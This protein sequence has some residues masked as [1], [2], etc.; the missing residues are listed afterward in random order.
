M[1][2]VA[3]ER[4]VGGTF[5]ARQALCWQL[6]ATPHPCAACHMSPKLKAAAGAGGFG[7]GGDVILG[8]GAKEHDRC[9]H[10][11][12]EVRRPQL[13]LRLAHLAQ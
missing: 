6:L 8:M 10:P 13:L 12:Q 7:S 5:P 1:P 9:P 4:G 3:A 2:E 11:G